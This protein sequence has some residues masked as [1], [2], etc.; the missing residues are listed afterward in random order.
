MNQIFT[1]RTPEVRMNEYFK[2]IANFASLKMS[3]K[4]YWFSNGVSTSI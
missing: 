3:L 1:C 2:Q 4:Y